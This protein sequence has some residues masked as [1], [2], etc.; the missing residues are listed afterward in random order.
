MSVKLGQVLDF[1]ELVWPLE[2]AEDWDRP[3]LIVG[4]RE[5]P[6]SRIL[7]TVDLTREVLEEAIAGEFDLI[8]THHP[9]LL[10]GVSTV[11]EQTVK[12]SLLSEAIRRGI[13]IFAA[14]TNADIVPDGVSDVLAQRIG[15]SDIRPLV[16]AQN[17]PAVGH[18]RI[19][20]LGS[21]MTLLEFA[22]QLAGLL[23]STATGVRV[24]G[25]HDLEIQTVAL[26]GGAGDSFIASA[27]ASGADVFVT[28][29]LRHHLTQDAMELRFV[30]PKAPCLIDISHWAAEWLWLEMAAQQLA[31]A[32]ENVQIVVSQIRTDPWDFVVTQ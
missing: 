15:L 25:P 2:G 6:V 22:R 20:K 5:Q 11:S 17:N 12:G 16:A 14:H 28:S 24:A 26:C 3:G 19:G 13:A 1:A 29:D 23:P 10:R 32:F 30:D 27:Q 18:G 7:L 31:S 9:Y 21:S 4:S 8:F